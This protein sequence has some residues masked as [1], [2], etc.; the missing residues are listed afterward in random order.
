MSLTAHQRSEEGMGTGVCSKRP[1]RQG[2]TWCYV[3]RF[4]RDVRKRSASATR[5]DIQECTSKGIGQQA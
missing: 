4:V 2:A 5:C 3:R 1:A